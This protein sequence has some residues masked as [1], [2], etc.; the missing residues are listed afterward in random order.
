MAAEWLNGIKDARTL[1]S[2]PAVALSGGNTQEEPQ[3]QE[4]NQ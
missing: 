3:K 1:S 2:A 4:E